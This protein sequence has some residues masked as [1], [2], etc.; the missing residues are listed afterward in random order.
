VSAFAGMLREVHCPKDFI[1]AAQTERHCARFEEKPN[2]LH[3]LQ[4]WVCCCSDSTENGGSQ[5]TKIGR[6]SYK[7]RS[8][9]CCCGL[10]ATQQELGVRSKS[11]TCPLVRELAT[12]LHYGWTLAE[13]RRQDGS[14]TSTDLWNQRSGQQQHIFTSPP[15]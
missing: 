14:W 1:A 3:P 7:G 6:G 5:H 4:G 13:E 15:L 10:G 11:F 9:L 8:S 2:E 12:M